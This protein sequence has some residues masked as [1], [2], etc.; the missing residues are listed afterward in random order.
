[1]LFT[2]NKTPLWTGACAVFKKSDALKKAFTF[3]DRYDE[4]YTTYI[5]KGDH[6]HVP[7]LAVPMGE[8]KRSTGLPVTFPKPLV[9]PRNEMQEH[10]IAKSLHTFAQDKSHIIQAG[11]GTG[12]S[13]MSLI[14]A[15]KLGLK[16]LI[17]V[18]KQDIMSQWR[19]S[20]IKFLGIPVSD[21]GKIQQ[22]VCNVE[23]KTIVIGM[24]QSLAKDKYKSSVKSE[25]GLVIYDE[26]HVMGANYFSK[27]CGLFNSKYRLGLSATPYRSDGREHVFKDHIGEIAVV[28]DA[29]MMIPRVVVVKSEF[30]LPRVKKKVIDRLTGRPKMV[31]APMQL[32][33]GRTMHVAKM[34]G[35]NRARNE[36]ISKFVLAAYE[37]GRRTIIFSDLRENH[38]ERLYPALRSVGIP[39][40]DIAYYVG[41]MKEKELDKSKAAPVI[42]A[43]Y[44]MVA[45]ATDIPW[46]DT[47]VLATPRSDIVQCVGRILRTHNPLQD[48]LAQYRLDKQKLEQG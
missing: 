39:T 44:K 40:K 9:K 34:L 27:A 23:G 41:G 11:T 16:T 29:V 24:V 47:C 45:M 15:Q 18:P 26:I 19:D 32:N 43:T 2:Y 48:V 6:I 7:R 17:I 42:L 21:I 4:E 35:T 3:K 37:K 36:L 30:L 31:L 46:L 1:L 8:D 13:F 22:D 12:K 10:I 33:A 14:I 5:E 38:L 20:I 25:F 28:N